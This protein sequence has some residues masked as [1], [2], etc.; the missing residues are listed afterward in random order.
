MGNT[1]HTAGSGAVSMPT[2]R[3]C[4]FDPP[5]E[6]ERL[7]DED[8]LRRLAYPDGHYGWLVTGYALARAILADQ[9]FSSRMELRRPPVDWPAGTVVHGE[10]APPGFFIGMDPPEHT[11]YRRLLTGQFTVRRMNALRPRIEQVVKD[12]LDGMERSGPPV[13]L[14]EAFALPVPSLTLCDLLGVPYEDHERF[15]HLNAV[16]V[17]MESTVRDGEAAWQEVHD[18]LHAQVQRKRR[19]PG[20]D[21][22]SGLIDSGELD[23]SELVGVGIQLL[24]AGFDTTANMLA[25]GTFA[26]LENPTQRQ[27]LTSDSASVNGVVEEIL[28]HISVLQFTIQRTALEDVDLDGRLVKAGETVTVALQAANRDPAKFAGP[29]VL[30]VTRDA[31]GHLGFGHGLHQC[32]G[33]QLARIEMQAGLAGLFR[34]FPTLE[35]A[36]PAAEVPV[37]D[38]VASY[39]VHQLSVTWKVRK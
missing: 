5:D 11:R 17:S 19:Q 37:H 7:R 14:V 3:S 36:V 8:P 32:I 25:L 10:L 22:L 21:V 38:A 35:L 34:R 6:L 15:Q 12:C 13:D 29:G 26:L 18:Y 20:T 24:L 16:L 30:D 23:D 28:R 33:Q 27:L 1:T 9:R 4:P 39:G 31:K 2:Q